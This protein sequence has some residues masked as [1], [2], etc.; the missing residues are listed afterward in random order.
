MNY[1]KRAILA[2]AVFAFA[3]SVSNA[4]Q[5]TRVIQYHEGDQPTIYCP[6]G[7]VCEIRLAKGERITNPWMGQPLWSASYG[8]AGD[9]PIFTVKPEWGHLVTN[10][11]LGTDAG[12]DYHIMLVA[13][14]YDPNNP[15]SHL[16]APLYTNYAYD[17][18]EWLR[19]KRE[20]ERRRHEHRVIRWQRPQPPTVAQQMDAACAGMPANE[21][22]GTDTTPSELRPEGLPRH[23]GRPVCHNQY[24]TY[25]QM[26]IGGPNPTDV[27]ALIETVNGTKRIVNYSYD[28][29]SRIFKVDDVA[30]EYALTT[31]TGKHEVNLRIQWQVH[32]LAEPQPCRRKNSASCVRG[33]R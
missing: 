23:G 27:P 9:T 8:M 26:P 14:D 7:F 4:D 6:T 22:Y 28:A 33:K 3:H 5:L 17:D 2:L 18:E 25:I 13:Y 31:G 32:K 24:A 15:N 19:I 1:I 21:E 11:V 29:A 10:L 20:R 30:S 12:R 16:R